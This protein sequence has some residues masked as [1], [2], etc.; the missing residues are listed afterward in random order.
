MQGL[1]I[2]KQACRA[3]ERK[4][5]ERSRDLMHLAAEAGVGAAHWELYHAYKYPGSLCVNAVDGGRSMEHLEKGARLGHKAC[6]VQMHISMVQPVYPL[7]EGVGNDALAFFWLLGDIRKGAAAR[8]QYSGV[9]MGLFTKDPDT[10]DP[11]VAYAVAMLLAKFT[12]PRCLE[13]ALKW[14]RVA[15][16][17]GLAQAQWMYL[18][19]ALDVANPDA[20]LC[21]QFALE[22][23]NQ[24][25]RCA[26]AN[27]VKLF[28]GPPTPAEYVHALVVCGR[29]ETAFDFIPA[30]VPKDF[31]EYLARLGSQSSAVKEFGIPEEWWHEG[32]VRYGL[33]EHGSR[34]PQCALAAKQCVDAC[35]R[36][37]YEMCLCL[38]G[39]VTKDVLRYIGELLLREPWLWWRN[40]A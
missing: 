38:R 34:S 5:Y 14:V 15:A 21:N 31:D 3:R 25:M 13:Q 35:K 11:W 12:R 6:A 22:A 4:Q 10:E 18:N 23:S 7:P 8:A 1:E 16:E 30:E 24:R 9:V 27:L 20:L 28:M 19:F 17:K 26:C 37:V 36:A 40:E 33:S 29:S 2:Y 32:V 39:M